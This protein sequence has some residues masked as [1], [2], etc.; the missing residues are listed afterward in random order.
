MADTVFTFRELLPRLVPW[1]LRGTLGA[2]LLEAIGLMFD[3]LGTMAV[4]G[5]K[6]RLPGH[7]GEYDSLGLI[8][9]ERRI[10][11]GRNELDVSYAA[12][13]IPY[14]DHHRIRGGPYALLQQA[15]AFWA[16]TPFRMDLTYANGKRYRRDPDG[17][18]SVSGTQFAPPGDP[19]LWARWFLYYFWPVHVD[20]DGTWG[21]GGVWSD[22]GTW[23]TDLST[24]DVADLRLVPSEWNSQHPFGYV[25]LLQPGTELW[26]EPPDGLWSDP[27]VWGEEEAIT[28][29]VD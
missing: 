22:G 16:T 3:E 26:D 2:K 14:L 17:T 15:G 5:V 24:E 4:Q 18:I 23:D 9:R 6:R 8:G 10:R 1:W 19:L 11:R 29:S 28:I 13:L 20:R 21:S 7:D 27:G 12:R 25:I